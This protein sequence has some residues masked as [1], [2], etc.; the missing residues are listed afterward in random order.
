MDP[1]QTA[2]RAELERRAAEVGPTLEGLTVAAAKAEVARYDGLMLRLV[3]A[4]NPIVTLDYRHGR[5]NALVR[6]GTIVGPTTLG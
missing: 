5:I 6:D 3:D 1:E 4:A 2:R